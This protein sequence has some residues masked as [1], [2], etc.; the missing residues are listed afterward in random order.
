MQ[1]FS[2]M[3]TM[4]ELE[5]G[6]STRLLLN[7]PLHLFFSILILTSN[8]QFLFVFYPNSS[9]SYYSVT[10]F[11]A[12]GST[13]SQ[14]VLKRV[15]SLLHDFFCLSSGTAADIPSLSLSHCWLI[16]SQ[17][18]LRP[19]LVKAGTLHSCCA[20]T[21]LLN[22]SPKTDWITTDGV[23]HLWHHENFQS[24]HDLEHGFSPDITG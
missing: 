8:W 4:S 7:N 16:V 22:Y 6:P 3:W 24:G 13:F 11:S 18:L 2:W 12:P 21:A 20:T 14:P 19:C 5:T 17:A 23:M 10:L 1:P 15:W 9:S